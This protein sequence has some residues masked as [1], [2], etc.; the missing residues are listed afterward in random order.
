MSKRK[1]REITNDHLF[2]QNMKVKD[3]FKRYLKD[4]FYLMDNIFESGDKKIIESVI[5]KTVYLWTNYRGDDELIKKIIN[6]HYLE[7]KDYLFVIFMNTIL[8]F[9]KYFKKK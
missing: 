1:F 9:H 3:V 8:D 6:I 5:I 7:Q 4:E 2:L